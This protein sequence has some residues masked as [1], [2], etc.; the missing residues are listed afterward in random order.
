MT[1][2]HCRIGIMVRGKLRCLG[3]PLELKQRF[4]SGYKLSLGIREDR[5]MER[6]RV[7]RMLIDLMRKGL[8]V[9]TGSSISGCIPILDKGTG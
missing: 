7:V 3:S 9:K 5:P 1:L 2:K 8:D 6:Q 4:G